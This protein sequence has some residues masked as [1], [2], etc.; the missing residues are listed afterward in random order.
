M[1]MDAINR[2]QKRMWQFEV[3]EKQM[4][5]AHEQLEKK[6]SA[7]QL[8][9]SALE[10]MKRELEDVKRKD[11][12]FAKHVTEQLEAFR[13]VEMGHAIQ[14]FRGR[15]DNIVSLIS[16]LELFRCWTYYIIIRKRQREA[17]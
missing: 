11:K 8:N 13:K 12:D 4:M 7:L 17:L 2:L 15:W 16:P 9:K 14:G 3:G 1:A 5:Q 10:T 6:V